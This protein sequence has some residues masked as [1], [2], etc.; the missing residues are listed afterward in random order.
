MLFVSFRIIIKDD[1]CSYESVWISN[2]KQDLSTISDF[3]NFDFKEQDKYDV[4]FKMLQDGSLIDQIF[5]R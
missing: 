3:D 1:I 4:V 2:I 5:A